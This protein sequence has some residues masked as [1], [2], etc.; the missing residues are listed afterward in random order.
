MKKTTTITVNSG[1][2]KKEIH[3][4]LFVGMMI[5]EESAGHNCEQLIAGV[6][7][8]EGIFSAIRMLKQLE[9]QLYEILPVSRNLAELK[10]A[11]EESLKNDVEEKASDHDQNDGKAEDPF[12]SAIKLMFEDQDN[13]ANPLKMFFEELNQPDSGGRGNGI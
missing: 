1:S 2:M 11:M 13:K 7:G 3:G 4:D 5:S 10:L 9:N 8:I 6:S 12:L